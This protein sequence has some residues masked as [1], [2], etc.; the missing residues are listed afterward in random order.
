VG[1]P[2][3]SIGSRDGEARD[4][5]PNLL[6][7]GAGKCGT[8]SLH[9][10]LA[11]HPEVAMSVPKELK[12]FSADDWRARVAGYRSQFPGSAPVRGESSPGYTM[13]PFLPSVAERIHELIP[14]AKLVYVVRDPVERTIAQYAEFYAL[15]FEDRP[16][17]AALEAAAHDPGDQYLC[18]SRYAT[19]LRPFLQLFDPAQ[20]L[21]IDHHD[22][23][24]RREATLRE[25]F[26]FL[27]VDPS[28]TSPEFARIHNPREAKVRYSRLGMWLINRGI[29]T[30][31]RRSRSF[32]RAPLVRPVRWALSRPIDVTL[33]DATRDLLVEALLPEVEDLRGLTG[34]RFA[35]WPSFPVASP[36]EP[37]RPRGEPPSGR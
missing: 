24:H 16:I 5:L 3:S 15:R 36:V 19:Q 32:R 28:F 14:D 18:P 25:T 9:E 31:R 8:T 4:W 1:A 33:P 11:L 7:I 21:V 35:N 2:R 12:F 13:F 6:V 17:A 26:A 10:Y 23:L 34:K 29:L 27:G 37:T 20:I 30:E 22:L